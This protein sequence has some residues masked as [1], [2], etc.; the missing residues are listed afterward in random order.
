MQPGSR[1]SVALMCYGSGMEEPV[2]TSLDRLRATHTFPGTFRFKV[3]GE[4]SPAFVARV[5]QASVTV[6]GADARPSVT[7]RES[8]HGNHQSVSMTVTVRRAEEVLE[9]YEVLSSTEGVRFML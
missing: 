7:T 2:E 1:T 3:I 5:A 4:N 6:L 9:I 8:A